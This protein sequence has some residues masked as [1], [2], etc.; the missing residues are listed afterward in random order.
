MANTADRIKRWRDPMTQVFEAKY[1]T[2]KLDHISTPTD[3]EQTQKI[4]A[5]FAANDPPEV[6]QLPATR[7]YKR[8]AVRRV[9]LDLEP[10]MKRDNFDINVFAPV[11]RDLHLFCGKYYGL[12]MH[13]SF[14]VTMYNKKLFEEAGVPLPDDYVAKKRWTMGVSDDGYLESMRKLTRGE[15]EKKVWGDQRTTGLHVVNHFV[16]SWGGKI[17]NEDRTKFVM[18]DD[19][20]SVKAMQYQVD[21]VL[22]E[23]VYPA[24]AEIQGLGDTFLG[25]RRAISKTGHNAV[26]AIEAAR[27][28]GKLDPGMTF[29]PG[30]PAGLVP[31]EGPDGIAIPKDGK[32]KDQAWTF[33]SWTV[34]KEGMD[35]YTRS[36]RGASPRLD[37]L[38]DPNYLKSFAPW[39]KP[40][41]FL[42][43]VKLARTDVAVAQSEATT[44]FDRE[45]DLAYLGK[46]S[47]VDALRA[48]KAEIDPLLEGGER[49]G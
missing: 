36:G 7:D 29:A 21:L 27:E 26:A 15:G 30:G 20:N 45:M 8:V 25:G 40:A 23:K 5:M 28:A 13:L 4:L 32:S 49:C 14:Y 35:L 6:M 34:S 12:P 3:D 17:Y 2:I 31:R 1:P 16:F 24:A 42:E 46:K 44:I 22:K 43:S 11:A 47:V 37:Q 10:Y 19:P 9:L 33:L 18:P 48:A 39:E 41:I 38:E